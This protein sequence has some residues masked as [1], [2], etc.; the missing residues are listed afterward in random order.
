VPVNDIYIAM[1][2]IIAFRNQQQGKITQSNGQYDGDLKDGLPHGHGVYTFFRVMFQGS[3]KEL[4][5][6]GRYDGEWKEGLFHG[7]GVRFWPDGHVCF[8]EWKNGK[9]HGLG[10]KIDPNG[11]VYVGKWKK[12]KMHGQG[13]VLR[14]NNVKYVGTFNKGTLHGQGIR[15]CPFGTVSLAT[16]NDGN[17]TST[18]KKP[19]H[20]M[21]GYFGN[22][23]KKQKKHGL[24]LFTYPDST[25]YS[26]CRQYIGQCK[27]DLL[28][29]FGVL[30][31]P[32]ESR[33]YVGQ[34]QLD[35]IDGLG[36]IVN[37]DN[38]KHIGHWK[39][40]KKHG[41]GITITKEK[42]PCYGKWENNVRQKKDIVIYPDPEKIKSDIEKI[43]AEEVAQKKNHK[44]IV[45][46]DELPGD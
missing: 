13:V 33:Q 2:K 7:Q 8:G 15:I 30:S 34:F 38:R 35:T 24:G 43:H 12:G 36:V 45:S 5:F 23:N 20:N 39:N 22:T 31:W 14:P 27:N 10:A 32:I 46:I 3:K 37:F 17:I 6:Y 28:H 4:R 26:N 16:F 21:P 41:K 18:C 40:K 9:M 29:G 11:T 25:T 19:S 42:Q 1:N 44:H